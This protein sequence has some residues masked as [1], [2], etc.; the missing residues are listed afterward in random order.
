M[1]RALPPPTQAKG[2]DDVPG[3]PRGEKRLGTPPCPRPHT[4]TDYI[5][6]IIATL[7]SASRHSIP[8]LCHT[9]T[10]ILVRKTL[11]ILNFETFILTARCDCVR[12]SPA[13]SYKFCYQ[14]H[15]HSQRIGNRVNT[16][17]LFSEFQREPRGPVF[18]TQNELCN[19]LFCK[20][21]GHV[22]CWTLT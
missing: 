13:L 11:F 17:N 2:Q 12:F 18:R 3:E 5:G 7:I 10:I 1:I 4:Y 20:S 19:Y 21:S 15:S 8:T 22:H 16:Y 6:R 14:C 9:Y